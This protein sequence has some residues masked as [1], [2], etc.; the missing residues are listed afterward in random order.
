MQSL[1]THGAAQVD[2]G[3]L[4]MYISLSGRVV[5]KFKELS[6]TGVF[7]SASTKDMLLCLP[8]CQ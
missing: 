4:K 6:K 2:A 5:K 7:S 1:F 8:L 3:Q